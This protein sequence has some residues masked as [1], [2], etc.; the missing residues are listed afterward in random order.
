VAHSVQT[1]AS[2]TSVSRITEAAVN[3]PTVS[4]YLATSPVPVSKDISVTVLI[5]QVIFLK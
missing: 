3:T 1:L 4:T 5:A 2:L